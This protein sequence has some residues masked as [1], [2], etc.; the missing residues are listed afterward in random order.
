MTAKYQEIA[1]TIKKQ[2]MNGDY[3]LKR[4]P[5]GRTL[6]IE[7]GVSYLT[8]R[9]AVQHLL[10][11]NV[12]VKKGNGRL[13]LNNEFLHIHKKLKV[14]LL[15]PNWYSPGFRKWINAITEAVEDMGGILKTVSYSHQNDPIIQD[16]M[17]GEFDLIF[18]EISQLTPA[19]ERKLGTIQA[20]VISLF[21]N[22]TELGI[23]SVD[24]PGPESLE[25][26]VKHLYEYGHREVA[27]LMTEPGGINTDERFFYWQECARKRG[28]ETI[29]ISDQVNP[30]EAADLKAY[31]V[32]KNRIKNKQINFTALFSVS[33]TTAQAA[34]RAFYEE[35]YK[36]GK[37]MSICSFGDPTL[38]SLTIPS[39]TTVNM[40][41]PVNEIKA[42]I[43]HTL[44]VGGK[45]RMFRVMKH[46]LQIG[47][48]TGKLIK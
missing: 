9:R 24:G 20:K 8:A 10:D 6:A 15:R 27:F 32:V 36:I 43:D 16:V 3:A 31:E 25:L 18:L 33:V 38:A 34:M 22:R 17:D 19:M 4:P 11:E 44:K 2:I 42:V 37:N 14:A 35:G 12:F 5:S 26:L 7:A 29:E 40:P 28:M 30:F 21:K 39:I 45:T 48:S 1:A 41:Y 13:E 23:N 46:E 47:E